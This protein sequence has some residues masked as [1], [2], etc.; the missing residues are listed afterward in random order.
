MLQSVSRIKDVTL[1]SSDGEIGSV[2]EFYFDDQSWA[3]RYLVVNTGDWL[4]GRLV[5]ISPIFLGAADWETGR[6]DITLT[7]KQIEDSPGIDRHRPV[8]RQHEAAYMDYYGASYYWNGPYMWGG[9]LIPADLAG[10]PM[11]LVARSATGDLESTDSHLRS[12]SEVKEYH[13]EAANGEIGHVDD[14]V[15]DPETWSIRYL[16]VATRTWWP[17]KKVLVSPE[18]IGK[19][20]WGES[21][22]RVDLSRETIQSAPEYIESVPITREYEARLL[23]HY[24]R[25]PYWLREAKA[26]HEE[27]V[28]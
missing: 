16:E 14:F 21:S 7:K 22:V 8:S 4:P 25:Q 1:H 13:I 12:T 28:R 18:W 5:L 26:A 10:I 20:S 9:A 27:A 11:P 17:G 15:V 19:I 6:L 24:G 3:I 23:E 2:E